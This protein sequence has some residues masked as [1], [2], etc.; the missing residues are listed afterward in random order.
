MKD[1]KKRVI[2]FHP[3]PSYGGAD[4][5]IIKMINVLENCEIYF[6]SLTKC[7]YQNNIKKKIKY[8]TLNKK[9][10]LFSIFKLKKVVTKLVS[11]NRIKKNILIS[12]QNFA[13]IISILACRSITKLKIL[14]IERNHLDELRFNKNFLDLLKKKILL[15]LI[16]WLYKKSN[17]IIGISKNLSKDLSFH[18]KKKVTTIYNAALDE[19]LFVRKSSN[20]S[21]KI[22]KLKRNKKFL[23]LNVALFEFQK[24]HI[25][26]LK[27]FKKFQSKYKETYLILIGNGSEKSKIKFFIKE[28]NLSKNVILILDN[29]NP[30][31]YYKICNLFILSSLYEGFANV[32][33]ESLKNNCPVISSKCE[34]GPMEIIKNGKFGDFFKCKDYNELAHKIESHYL[35]PNRL[36]EK[37]KISQGHIKKFNMIQYSKKINKIINHIV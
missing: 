26:L 33:V 16:K 30:K 17:S 3:Y 24:D 7:K 13:N 21:K 22:L 18:C 11:D 2:I 5:S 23:I 20:I 29:K 31:K 28:N 36:L 27:A 35:N 10:T 6:I 15:I 19:S 14:L 34:S 37:C 25:T 1:N 32:I 12:N 4:R 9:R 8:I